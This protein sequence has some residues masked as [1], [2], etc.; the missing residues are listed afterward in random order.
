VYSDPNRD[1]Q[2]HVWLLPALHNIPVFIES[3]RDGS[4]NSRAQLESV[5]FNNDKTL[6]Q[7][8]DDDNDEDANDY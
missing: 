5:K 3:Y 7:H 1:R 8:P 6:S 4:V 2:L